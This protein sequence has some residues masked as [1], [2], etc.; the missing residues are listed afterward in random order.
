MLVCQARAVADGRLAVGRFGDPVAARLL[1]GDERTEVDLARGPVPRGLG[2]R[3]TY[4]FLTG[5]ADILATRTVVIDDAVRAGRHPQVVLL[6]AGLDARAW[7]MP[8]LADATVFEVDQPAS[9]R[10]KKE[11]VAGLEPAAKSVV[12]VPV[13]FGRD[14][15]RDAL[16]AAGHDPAVPTTWIWEGVLPYLTQAQVMSTLTEVAACSAPGSRIAVT[17][18]T[19]NRLNGA[20]LLLLKVVC[21]IARRQN[22]LE[23][24]PHISAW[25]Q[26][27]MATLLA[28]HGAQV[29]TD[30]DQLATARQLGIVPRRPEQLDCGRVG[31]AD[32]R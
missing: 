11:R 5:T 15:L 23:H 16:V 18:S 4:E 14:S 13:E 24:E 25:A 27:R 17:Y 12:F 1:R 6:G 9:Q 21:A 31:I 8:E 3:M 20:A 29:S 7:R 10:D 30:V 22:P 19:K 2:D 26:D 32:F 28:S